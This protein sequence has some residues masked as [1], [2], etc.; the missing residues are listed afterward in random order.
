MN[1]ARTKKEII[2]EAT[3]VTRKPYP[4][5]DTRIAMAEEKITR[6]QNLNAS[7]E[8]L[9]EKNVQKLTER[10]EA[11]EKSRSALEK[12]VLL[13]DHL[14]AIKDMPKRDYG[15]RAAKAAEKATIAELKAK[16]EAA[17]GSRFQYDAFVF[18]RS[19]QELE[20]VRRSASALSVPSTHH[21][22]YL[23]CDSREAIAEL[24]KLFTALPHEEGEAFSPLDTGAFWAVPVG[25]TV[26][27]A[28]G[29]KVLGDKKYKKILTSRNIGTVDKILSVMGASDGI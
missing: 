22:Y 1:M 9:I 4:N 24:D 16:L 12:A 7:R 26:E 10:R 21:L 20:A 3:K 17:L 8:E 15:I 25:R 29:S 2:R 27:S 23:I 13:R 19:R 5:V 28:F 6:L 14:L 11:L 18:L